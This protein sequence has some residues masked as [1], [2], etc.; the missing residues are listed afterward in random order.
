MLRREI[1]HNSGYS[2]LYFMKDPSN[3]CSITGLLSSFLGIYF[4]ITGKYY[5]ALIGLL[6]AV[7]FDWADGIIARKLKNRTDYHRAVGTQL[8]SLIDIVSFGILPA[9]ILLSFGK[10]KPAFLPG[11]FLIV[12]GGAVRLSYFNV[13]GMIDKNTYK[14]L[15]LDNNA[16][17]LSFIFIFDRFLSRKVFSAVLY[18]VM[19]ILLAFNLA[20]IRTRKL[21]AGWLYI[22]IPYTV[23]MSVYYASIQ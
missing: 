23:I 3:I 10:F 15:A 22:L 16:I 17:I 12:A 19:L 11:A 9:V 2:M 21:G 18:A 13:F 20:P 8:D 14:G 7:I 1:K 6:W 4:S 5:Y